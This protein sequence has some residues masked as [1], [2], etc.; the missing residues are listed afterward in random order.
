MTSLSLLQEVNDAY[1]SLLKVSKIHI[2]LTN[3]SVN[4]DNTRHFG[5]H[6]GY[7]SSTS[8]SESI[9][10]LNDLRRRRTSTLLCNKSIAF[11]S[12]FT[13]FNLKFCCCT[14]ACE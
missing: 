6:R 3:V 14:L 1:Y 9:L 2:N 8:P 5:F 12:R 4:Y 10:T 13:V 11:S 7:L